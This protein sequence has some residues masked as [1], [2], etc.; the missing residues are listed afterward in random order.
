MLAIDEYEQGVRAGNRAILA[1]AIT[2]IE[3]ERADH[4]RSA[5]ELLRRLLPYTGDAVRVGVS[6][7]P[8]AGKST[9][10]N[11]LGILLV[12]EGHRVAVLTVDP[13]STI[14][15]GSILGDKTR[16][17]QLAR[18]EAAYIRP[19]PSSGTLGGVARKT[20]ESML[21]CEAAGFDVVLV[22]TVGVGQSEVTVADM[23]DITL[24]VLIAGAGR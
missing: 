15:G 19:A 20:R 13:S 21:L 4:R 9:L 17:S 6:G 1:R 23:V 2:L 11:A 7:V 12:Q 22:E 24:A 8:G 14:S 3:S 10:I 5:Q 18:E 16:M